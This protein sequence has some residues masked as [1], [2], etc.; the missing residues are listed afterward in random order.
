VSESMILRAME[1]LRRYGVSSEVRDMATGSG[2][3][4]VATLEPMGGTMTWA[5]CLRDRQ[6]AK[7]EMKHRCAVWS[8]C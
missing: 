3:H 1:T 5:C 7:R 2:V 6:D 8:I 4:C